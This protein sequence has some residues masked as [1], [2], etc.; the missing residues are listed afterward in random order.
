[1]FKKAALYNDVDSRY[2]L[3]VMYSKGLGADKNFKVALQYFALASA[4]GHLAAAYQQAK[5]LEK[6]LGVEKNIHAV[7]KHF[8]LPVH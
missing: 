6:G 8:K 2:Y 4:G 1:M 7:K 3:G 5:M